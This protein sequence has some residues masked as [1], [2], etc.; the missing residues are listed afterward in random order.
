MGAGGLPGAVGPEEQS[1]GLQAQLQ[2][3]TRMQPQELT[4]PGWDDQLALGG[5]RQESIQNRLHHRPYSSKPFEPNH[6]D[7]ASPDRDRPGL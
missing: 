5:Q 2:P 6:Q 1:I 4:Q 3:I 7:G